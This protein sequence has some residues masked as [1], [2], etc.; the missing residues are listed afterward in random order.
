MTVTIKL[1]LIDG[2]GE[3]GG[4]RERRLRKCVKPPSAYRSEAGKAWGDAA[5]WAGT[6]SGRVGGKLCSSLTLANA[7]I[8]QT[9]N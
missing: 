7:V 3:S 4:T 6:G 8:H 1:R 5:G 9:G 2:A